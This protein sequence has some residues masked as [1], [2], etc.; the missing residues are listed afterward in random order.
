MADSAE[1]VRRHREIRQLVRH[2]VVESQDALVRALEERGHQV[3]QSTLSRDLK[4]LRIVRVPTD[5]GY[6][7][8]PQGAVAEPAPDETALT[9]RLRATAAL[10]V[11]GVGANETLVVIRTLVGRAQG[12]AVLLDELELPDV[13]GTVAGDDTILVVP[14]SVKRVGRLRRH[15]AELLGLN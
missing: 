6:R 14:R 11:T 15:L 4:E 10:E 9:R 12:V 1:K 2:E 7:Y 13:L 8:L 5:G 3:A